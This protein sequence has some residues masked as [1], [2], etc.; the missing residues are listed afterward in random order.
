MENKRIGGTDYMLLKINS[1]SFQF[2]KKK[3]SLLIEK[4]VIIVVFSREL[5]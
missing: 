3:R 4:I 2:K 1:K 5:L